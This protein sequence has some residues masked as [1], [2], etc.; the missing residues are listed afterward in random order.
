MAQL[1]THVLDTMRGK[2]ADA[3]T[4]HLY[5]VI[6]TESK[7]YLKSVKT[8]ADGRCDEPLLD[9]QQLQQENYELVFEV[10][11]YFKRY[12]VESPF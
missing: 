6:D 2:P 12:G 4:I 11:P 7:E 10:E 8:N 9:S 1:S 5:R 3:L